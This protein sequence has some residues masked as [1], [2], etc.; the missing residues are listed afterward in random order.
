MA[1]SP[2]AE[3]PPRRRRGIPN[4]WNPVPPLL[5]GLCFGLAF[6]GTSRLLDGRFASLVRLGDRFDVKS[7]P[8]TGL[9]SL[10]MRFGA[11]RIDLHGSPEGLEP[12]ETKASSSSDPATKPSD[13][14]LAPPAIKGES[15]LEKPLTD[16]LEALKQATAPPRLPQAPQAPRL[17]PPPQ[18]PPPVVPPPP[19][20]SATVVAPPVPWR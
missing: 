7:F 4:P 12:T 17:P 14:P 19:A 13:D 2:T 9:E 5:V 6:A 18:L 20:G 1:S 10:R 15:K 11:E 8:G 3:R 16:P